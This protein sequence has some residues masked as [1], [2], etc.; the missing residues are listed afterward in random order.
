MR[1]SI[2]EGEIDFLVELGSLL[3]RVVIV[4]ASSESL[5]DGTFRITARIANDGFL[6]TRTA[7]GGQLRQPRSIRVDLVTS[8]QEIASGRRIQTIDAIPGSGA[9]SE[10]TWTVVGRGNG[11]VT[12]RAEA[13]S[14]GGDSRE[15][16]LR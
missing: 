13:P 5:G 2:I 4:E 14:A 1:D 15:V 6:P 11:R 9:A 3:P 16:E 7:V 10:L 8:G 12:V